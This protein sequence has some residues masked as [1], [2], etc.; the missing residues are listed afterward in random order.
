M[1]QIG[2]A[3][4]MMAN[5]I[6]QQNM[7]MAQN[8]QAA[9]HHWKTARSG[10]TASHVSQPQEQMGLT[11]FMRHNPPKFTGNATPDQAD[12][13]IRELEK[14]F[15]A[16]S[17]PENKKLV[18]ATY[19]LSKEAEF[20]WMGAQQ[21]M[22]ARDEVLD[23]ESFR[24]KFLEKYFSDSARFA[25]EAEFLKL[26]QGEMSVNAYAIRFEYLARFYT[27]AT[28]EAWRCRKFE[29]GLKHELKKTI[30]PMCIREFPALVEK[31][32]MVETLENGDSR[33]IRSHQGG[34]SSGK[35]KVQHQQHKPYARPPQHRTGTSL[36]QFQQQQPWRPT[37]YHCAGPHLKK[38]CPQLSSE[39]KCYTCRKEGHL[40][41]DCPNRRRIIPG[42][43]LQSGRGGGGRP[44]A[45]GRVFAML[46]AEA[47]QSGM[48]WL[49]ANHILIDC[50]RQKIVFSDSKKSYGMSA[51]QVWSELKEGSKCFVMLTQ[52]EV[53]NEEEMSSIHVVKDFMDVFPEEIPGLPPKREVEFSIDLV[54]EAGPVSMAPYRMAP[55][56]L[57]ELKKQVEDL[58]EKQFI[59]PS[60]ED[61]QK[62]A[63]RSRY[64]HYEYVV[65]PFGVTN[66]PALFMDYMNRIFRPFLDK[67]VIVFIDDILIYSRTKGEHEEHL[68]TVL[69]ILREKQLY[70]KFSKCE[71][72]LKEVNFLG[73]VIS[74]Q[75]ISVDPAKVEAVLQWE[76]P[77]TVTEIRS[78]VGLAGYYRR[79]IEDFS[80]VVAPLTQLTRK[81]QPFAWTDRCEQS[82]IELRKRLTSAPVLVIPDTGKPFE[83]YCDASHQGLGCVLMQ[84]KRPVAYASRQLKVH[85]RNYPTHDLELAALVFALKIWRHYLYGAQFQV[86]SDHK[87]L[88][89]LFDQKELNMRQRRWMEFLKDYDFQLMYHPGKANVVADALNSLG[90]RLRMSSAYHPQTD[91]QS[92]RTIQ[93]LED[94]LRTCILDHL[95]SLDEMLPLVEF[96]YNNSYH[97]SIGM[98]PYAALY[99]R[100]C[101]TP[102]CW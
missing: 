99:G 71:F 93:S 70:A 26:E 82:F 92:E 1:N 40:S 3:I 55:V 78:F 90:T 20:W 53:K 94:L 8:H 30:A 65:M 33:V 22:E 102:L 2:R 32:K 101:R 97:A 75:G 100:K 5:A 58:L 66:A 23:W 56:E 10:A 24:V 83:V 89:Y 6:Q 69:E 91:G 7:A 87:S 85:E 13:W 36:P 21:M 28:S 61:V 59:R 73:H 4:E 39:R 95:G 86:F 72:W 74:I 68:K 15:R 63:F 18:F 52:M 46:G 51:Q 49:S 54:P 35:A 64:G 34:S 88:K 41:K 25:K 31:A 84:E 16:T 76:R 80:R 60:A 27:Q 47:S 45:T 29:E 67:F 79:F 62:T 17:C 77:K 37:C 42:G 57:I 43:N 48:D 14:I 11:E 96:T 98:A 50:G 12:Q 81:D 44:Q 19:L 38:D 9:M